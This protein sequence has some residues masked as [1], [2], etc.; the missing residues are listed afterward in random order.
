MNKIYIS[1]STN[2]SLRS[3]NFE[4]QEVEFSELPN[5]TSNKHYSN[6]SFKGG[7]RKEKYFQ[8]LSVL[9]LD[10]DDGPSIEEMTKKLE[11]Y[12]ALIVTTKSNQLT[13]K[14]GKP[15]TQ[16]DRYRLFLPLKEPMI[17]ANRYKIVVTG[18][19]EE[20]KADKACKDLARFYYC[21]PKQ[22]VHFIE[23][24]KY[25]DISQYKSVEK[26]KVST[27]PKTI[28]K[29]TVVTD[30][31]G[32][33]ETIST[34]HGLLEDGEKV[35]VHCPI[36]PEAH[37]NGDAT[38]SCSMKKNGSY[39]NLNCFGCNSKASVNLGERSSK[40]TGKS[41]FT[42][43]A[44]SFDRES[45]VRELAQGINTMTGIVSELVRLLPALD[46]KEKEDD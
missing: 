28:S 21:N 15:I 41:K 42:Y 32:N 40:S 3:V 7:Y 35:M 36:S 1:T 10:I 23:G 37:S 17:D 18:L 13:E 22:E 33:E 11:G 46:R 27:K 9:I 31:D 5:I 39:M 29:V 43:S 20:F 34:F 2:N 26:Q 19:I 6:I 4:N 25:W 14:N 8:G 38:P 16:C 12:K 30:E 44:P 45:A 24:E